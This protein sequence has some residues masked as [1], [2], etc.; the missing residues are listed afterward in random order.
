MSLIG[1]ISTDQE[2]NTTIE[3]TLDTD[4]YQLKFLENH[5][6]IME[7]L[8][9]D[10]PEIVIVN[11]SDTG[12]VIATILDSIRKDAWLHNFGIVGVFRPSSQDEDELLNRYHDLNILAMID[13]GR[14]ASHFVRVVQII[15]QNRQIIFQRELSDK[16]VER[17][18]GSFVIENDIFAVG[19][20]AGIAA[21]ILSQRSYIKPESKMHLQL[22]LDELIVNGVEHGNCGITFEEKSEFLKDGKGIVDLVEEKCQDPKVAQ[23]K[24]VL[25]WEIDRDKTTFTIAD[26]GNGFDVPCLKEKLDKEGPLALH[27]R[28]IRMARA[29]AEKLYYNRKGNKVVILIRHDE[30]VDRQAPEGFSD[31]EGYQVE[32]GA[33]VFKEGE[34]SD[35]LYYIQSGE[36]SVYHKNRKVGIMTTEDIFM[37]EMSFLLNNQRSAMVKAETPGRLIKISRKSFVTVI[38]E[39]PHY[40]IFLSKLLARKLVR[41]N[42]LNAAVDFE[43]Q[44]SPALV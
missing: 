20:Y 31:E 41:A 10:L 26:E 13:A 7:C 19:V 29:F 6:F 33:V 43:G 17:A 32:E 25:E 42:A 27:G 8:N 22:C 18:A 3:N 16:L 28:G 15:E 34:P 44:K 11:F 24:V 2:L 14:V 1:V 5:E 12:L 40:G 36:Y 39:Y 37:G 38:K 9:F 30:S 4:E 23:K 35:F 21:T